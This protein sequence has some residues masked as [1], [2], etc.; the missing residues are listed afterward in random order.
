MNRLL[1]IVLV[2]FI[3]CSLFA[4]GE[5]EQKSDDGVVE[6]RFAWWGNAPRH[7][8]HE[9]IATLFEEQNPDIRIIR[10]PSSWG[11]YW[12]KLATQA[13][14]GNPP[15]VLT[16]H[17]N[18]S[19]RYTRNGVLTDLQPFVEKG[20]LDM[21]DWSEGAIET[22]RDL[23]IFTRLSEG[24]NSPS[25]WV[26]TALVEQYGL[27]MPEYEMSWDEWKEY[28]IENQSRL[29]EGVFMTKDLSYTFVDVGFPVW[30]RQRV[31]RYFTGE[32]D[33]ELSFGPGDLT[34]WYQY[35]ADL[36]EM[37]AVMPPDVFAEYDG[38]PREQNYVVTE[39]IV[40]EFENSNQIVL[41]QDLMESE[42]QLHRMPTMPE[43][44][45]TYGD[46]TSGAYLSISTT[47]DHPEEA[48]RFANFFVNNW[49]AQDIFNAEHGRPAN[50]SVA[51]RIMERSNPL[52]QDFLELTA[53]VLNTAPPRLA[54]SQYRGQIVSALTLTGE[55]IAFGA[56]SIDEA[57]DRFFNE[58]NS[59]F[60]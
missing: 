33:E 54:F 21:S 49:G 41:T 46:W 16:M 43:G 27:S 7:E 8:K 31:G 24:E 55:Q 53:N 40:V 9:Q 15:D 51:A 19:A 42:L 60:Q 57:V 58:A 37:G 50:D 18:E 59:I 23:G 11:D 2:F 5:Q 20:I 4:G 52:Q 32:D 25:V 36:R 48:A 39:R 10:E 56:L 12:T 29:P 38:V 34:A 14:A 45:H 22:G 30:L 1:I 13:A 47:T 28:F 26:N 35:W 44:K 17:L 3:A 6:L